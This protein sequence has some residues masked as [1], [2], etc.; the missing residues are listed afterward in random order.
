M[1]YRDHL[2]RIVICIIALAVGAG[3]QTTEGPRTF[4]GS[5]STEIV[6]VQQGGSGFALQAT[7]PSTGPIGAVFGLASGASGFTNGIWGR[8]FSTAGVGARGE[9]MATSGPATGVA[10]FTSSNTGIGVFGHANFAGMGVVGKV[11]SQEDSSVGVMGITAGACC[12]RP[13]VF[14]QDERGFDEILVGQ[15]LNTASQ[16]QQAFVVRTSGASS[17]QFIATPLI[18]THTPVG[19]DLFIGRDN[20]FSNVFRV[21]SKGAVFSDGG[22]NTGG[23]DFAEALPVKGIKADYAPGDVLTIDETSQNRLTRAAQAYSTL[24]AGIY[25]TK[26]GLLGGSEMQA[27]VKTKVPLAIVGIVPCKV[28]TENGGIKAG[29]LLVT[30]TKPGYA[31]KGTDRS[32]MVGAVVGKALESLAK[33]DSTIQVLV[34]LQ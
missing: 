10:G 4:S 2:S 21:D 9:A 27:G 30:S 5:T 25:S 7:T 13:G 19:S 32:R 12:G 24:V 18:D 3:A 16:I 23:A 20:S 33:G 6:N 31:M 14:E 17:L 22:Y 28:T 34:T 11:D 29:D 26:P 15:F 1:L 8:S